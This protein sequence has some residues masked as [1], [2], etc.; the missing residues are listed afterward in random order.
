MPSRTGP[1]RTL[2]L[3]DHASAVWLSGSEYPVLRLVPRPS[4]AR[5][6]SV[7]RA[8][9][10]YPAS[11]SV[12]RASGQYPGSAG[13][14]LRAVG[15]LTASRSR[16]GSEVRPALSPASGLQRRRSHGVCGVPPAG[17]LGGRRWALRRP[18]GPGRAV[19]SSSATRPCWLIQCDSRTSI[20][21][22]MQII[23]L[24]SE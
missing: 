8:D 21:S 6:K 9:G 17:V 18:S 22:S 19:A 13:Q 3:R 11:G 2:G 14:Y 10:W 12:P 1:H 24:A 16:P 15:P 5:W 23:C 20:D 4:S 7:P